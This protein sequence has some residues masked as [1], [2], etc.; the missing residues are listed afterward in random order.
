MR[1]S[2]RLPYQDFGD[3]ATLAEQIDAGGRFAVD[4]D[5]LQIVILCIALKSIGFD[6]LHTGN[7]T[8]YGSGDRLGHGHVADGETAEVIGQSE[9]KGGCGAYSLAGRRNGSQFG[10]KLIN[11]RIYGA[12]HTG[13]IHSFEILHGDIGQQ[14]IGALIDSQFRRPVVL[15]GVREI[16]VVVGID[17]FPAGENIVFQGSEHLAHTWILQN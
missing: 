13:H 2:I 9:I 4:A 7:H 10:F 5:T 17:E 11:E 16:I 14:H 1:D 12:Y 6:I 3:L 8:R 15:L